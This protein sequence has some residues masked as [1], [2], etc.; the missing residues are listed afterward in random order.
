[1]CVRPED[2]TGGVDTRINAMLGD[3]LYV[4]AFLGPMLIVRDAPTLAVGPY[5][6]PREMGI[7]ERF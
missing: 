2:R 6:T 1:M 5:L 4:G 7:A 3:C